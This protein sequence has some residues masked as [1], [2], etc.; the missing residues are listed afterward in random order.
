MFSNSFLVN[1]L[2]SVDKVACLFD[3][4]QQSLDIVVPVIKHTL[5]V[6]ILLFEC[7]LPGE[8]VY[9]CLDSLVNDHIADF[10]FSSVFG[11]SYQS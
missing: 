8:S 9:L 6:L 1:D 2:F 4:V 7:D 3:L 5:G 10:L 11:D